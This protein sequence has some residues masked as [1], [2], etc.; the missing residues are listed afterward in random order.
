MYVEGMGKVCF[1][2]N[3][4]SPSPRQVGPAAFGPVATQHI[5]AEERD[6]TQLLTSQRW[7]TKAGEGN[8]QGPR[9]TCKSIHIPHVQKASYNV[10]PMKALPHSNNA[11][12]GDEQKS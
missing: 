10:L 2:N 7:E 4:Q 5:V 6:G 3:F 8:G 1:D 9:I 12:L 11:T